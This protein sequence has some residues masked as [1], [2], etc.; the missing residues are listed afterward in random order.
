MEI[1]RKWMV[2]GWPEGLHPGF[3]LLFMVAAIAGTTSAV[4]IVNRLD[5]KTF[6]GLSRILIVLISLYCLGRGITMIY[7]TNP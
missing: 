7:L 3:M 2:K 1:E 5:D 4:P 6:K